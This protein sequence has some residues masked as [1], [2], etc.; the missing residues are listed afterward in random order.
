MTLHW[1]GRVNAAV[2]LWTLVSAAF[3]RH[4]MADPILPH[5]MA[6][7]WPP[8]SNGIGSLEER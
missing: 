6:R 3:F 2:G 8:I 1:Q 4:T 5:S 7:A